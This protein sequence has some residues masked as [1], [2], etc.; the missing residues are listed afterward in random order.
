M[1]GSE[2]VDMSSLLGMY[3]ILCMI[4]PCI[5]RWNGN[6]GGSQGRISRPPPVRGFRD[7]AIKEKKWVVFWSVFGVFRPIVM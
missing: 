5:V 6:K 4:I 2:K 1:F 3:Y 7:M